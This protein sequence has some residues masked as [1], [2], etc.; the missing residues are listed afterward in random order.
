[1]LSMYYVDNLSQGRLGWFLSL[2]NHQGTHTHTPSLTSLSLRH[3]WEWWH[4]VSST[5]LLLMFC[6]KWIC[7][8]IRKENACISSACHRNQTIQWCCSFCHSFQ[9]H[10][11]HHTFHFLFRPCTVHIRKI[12]FSIYTCSFIINARTVL[13]FFYFNFF[14]FE[15]DRFQI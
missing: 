13:S 1:M 2:W 9:I 12:S 10:F 7:K 5:Q 4:V 6:S 14:R 11:I 15:P 8:N 3:F